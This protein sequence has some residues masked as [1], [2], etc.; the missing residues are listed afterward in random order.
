MWR[1]GTL[2]GMDSEMEEMR[3]WAQRRDWR[4]GDSGKLARVAIALS[5]KSM[6]S[7]SYGWSQH[8]Y[9]AFVTIGNVQY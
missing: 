7:E 2:F 3:L 1:F 9:I 4:R 6:H 5:V 8:E